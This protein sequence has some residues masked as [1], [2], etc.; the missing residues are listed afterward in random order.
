MSS[1][2]R[3]LKQRKV[4]RVAL[5]YAVVAWLVVQVSATVMPAYHAPDWILP[6]FITTVALGF[7]VALVL[8]WAFEI[9][10]G[11]IEK[12]PEPS[13][14]L[15]AANK[16]RLWVLAALGLIISALGAGGYWIWHPLRKSSATSEYSTA[17]APT[18]PE[19][20]IAV[21]PF[22]NL[23]RDPDNAYFAIGIQDEILTRLSRISALKAI[24]RSSTQQYQSRPANLA[25]LARQ[26]GVANVLEG[27]VQKVGNAVHVNAQLIRAAT[28]D[29][30]WA[31]SYDRKLDDIFSVEAEIAG[32]IAAA[33]DAKLTGSEQ[34]LV[35][36]RP[37]NNTEAY[38]FY[39]RGLAEEERALWSNQGLENAV[40][41]YSEATKLDPSFSVAWA[42]IARVQAWMVFRNFD[43]SKE[44]RGAA[45][46]AL[47]A[48]TKLQ[49]DSIETLFAQAYYRYWILRDYPQAKVLFEQLRARAPNN[50]DVPD[51]LAAV[52][53]RQGLWDESLRYSE[54]AMALNPRDPAVLGDLALTYRATRRLDEAIKILD[55]KLELT[56]NDWGVIAVKASVYH[57]QGQLDRA[58]SLLAG[59]PFGLQADTTDVMIDQWLFD[60]NY[61][62]L[63]TSV[64]AAL[65]NTDTSGGD[66][67][68]YL[69]LVMGLAQLRSGDSNSA[70]ATFLQARNELEK[71]REREPENARNASILA[72]VYAELGEK[73][74]ALKEAERAIMLLPASKDALAGPVR[75]EK[76]AIV[77]AQVGEGDRAVSRLQR[78][79]N[80]SYADSITPALLRLD[81]FWD[82]LRSDSRFQEL[83]KDK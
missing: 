13:G 15:A 36:E 82:P 46:Q 50:S 28:D 40:R 49:P 22:E 8:A 30:L 29:H 57:A 83:C 35:A 7:P 39:L 2:F 78:L 68:K 62:K 69:L 14:R 11:V 9:K 58:R 4:Y 75:E 73:E 61:P 63:I 42:R 17:P 64:Q 74:L 23:S 20:S 65:Q 76:L 16:R 55:R 71:L 60:R 1:F 41:L 66:S 81:P 19:K 3:E 38:E 33:L 10:G 67:R 54:Q 47:D 70:N 51:A 37:T 80:V 56:P 18:I 53:R 52:A 59:A 5:R 45:K 34:K 25:E 43:A 48:A 79:L 27:S 72:R 21:L 44:R 24:S 6:I 32:N 77:E 12:T 26:L 31:E